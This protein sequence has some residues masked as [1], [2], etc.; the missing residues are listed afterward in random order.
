MKQNFI[1]FIVGLLFAAGLAVSGMTQPQKVIGFLDLF[2]S[3]D[4]S[5]MF[6]MGGAI[7]V[8]ALVYFFAIKKPKPV[9]ADSWNVPN[10]KEITPS[11][12][13]GA[14]LFGSGWGLAGYC[15][16]PAITSLATLSPAIIIF[17]IS[18][19]SGMLIFKFVDSKLQFKR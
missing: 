10:K 2:G 5:L 16:G 12:I 8:H 19:I 18:M 3:W 14:I 11:L 9:C 1:S 7:G 4:P 13:I 17:V 6:V 15:P